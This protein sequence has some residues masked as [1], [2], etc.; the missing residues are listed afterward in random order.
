MESRAL[1][2]GTAAAAAVGLAALLAPRSSSDAGGTSGTAGERRVAETDRERSDEL[3]SMRLR[4]LEARALVA[5]IDEARVDDALDADNP[6][7][8]L[9]HLLVAHADAKERRAPGPPGARDVLECWRQFQR[10]SRRRSG[11][12]T[13]SPQHLHGGCAARCAVLSSARRPRWTL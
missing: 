2:V 12:S 1:L 3:R 5:G 6:K 13:S 4:A 8:E 11:S 7:E 9:V 10:R